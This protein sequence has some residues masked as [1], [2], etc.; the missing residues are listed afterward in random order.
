MIKCVIYTWR[1]EAELISV[2][3]GIYNEQKQ[4]AGKAINSILNQTERDIEFIICDDGS[5][6]E[7]YNWLI[8]FCSKDNRIILL[9][10]KQNLGLSAALNKCLSHAHGEYIA[11]M[12]GDD[13][14]D[15]RRLEKQLQFLD[16]HPEYSLTGCNVKFID[17]KGIW[18][19]RRLQEIP[20]NKDFL[21]TSPFVHP[22]IMIRKNIMDE[23]G[24]YSEEPYAVRTEDYELFMRLYA[25]GYKG[26]NLQDFLF[27]YREDKE[28]YKKRRYCY[29]LNESIVRYKGFRELGILR[30]NLRFVIKPL[31]VGLV[32]IRIIK[33]VR[34]RKFEHRE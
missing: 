16:S 33:R 31:I 21:Y 2:I 8:K 23:L 27:F 14:S 1:G 29:R 7:F 6:K 22:S 10:N 24:G 17:S 12:D 13:I 5:D 11:R 30:G 20:Q 4:N 34:K 25:K 9:R 3:M 15:K 18:G 28:A 32:P 26:Y 19:E